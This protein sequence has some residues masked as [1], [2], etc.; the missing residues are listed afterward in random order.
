MPFPFLIVA[1]IAAV[2]GVAGVG[3]AVS[4]SKDKRTTLLMKLSAGLIKR[5]SVPMELLKN[6]AS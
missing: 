6:L 1:G 4:A 5:E 2:A 3:A